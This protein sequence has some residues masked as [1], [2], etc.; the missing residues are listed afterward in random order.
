MGNLFFLPTMAPSQRRLYCVFSDDLRKGIAL[1]C[2]TGKDDIAYVQGK[3]WETDRKTRELLS[4]PGEIELYSP[5]RSLEFGLREENLEPLS[6]HQLISSSFPQSGDEHIH[7]VIKRPES[8]ASE[9]K[10][11]YH[12]LPLAHVA[13]GGSRAT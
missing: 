3:I 10:T 9:G 13:E 7:I 2:T 6:F 11:S 5:K 4:H 8:Y 12:K 1:D